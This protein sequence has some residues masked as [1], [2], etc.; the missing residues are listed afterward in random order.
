[1]V[2]KIDI[3]GAEDRACFREPGQ[4]WKYGMSAAT[5]T[6]EANTTCRGSTTTVAGNDKRLRTGSISRH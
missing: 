6:K 4:F 5:A 1:M 3:G 2:F